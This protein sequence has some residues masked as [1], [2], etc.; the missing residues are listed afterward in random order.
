[1]CDCKLSRHHL[2]LV[3]EGS[4]HLP[5]IQV[6]GNSFRSNLHKPICDF[7]TDFITD[8]D[9]VFHFSFL[10]SKVL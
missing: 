4:I 8:Q 2:I 10:Y 3:N 1:M 6:F 9:V 7:I 5:G